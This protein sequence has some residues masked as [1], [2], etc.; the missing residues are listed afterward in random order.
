MGICPTINYSRLIAL[1]CMVVL[2]MDLELIDLLSLQANAEAESRILKGE[3]E[4]YA[5][6][7]KVN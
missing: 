2:A 3:A 4:A 5:V 6:A 1:H 7:M